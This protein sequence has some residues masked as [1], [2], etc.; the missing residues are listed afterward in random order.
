MDEQP[1]PFLSLG[2]LAMSLL[3]PCRLVLGWGWGWQ[4]SEPV[5]AT[6]WSRRIVDT[7]PAGPAS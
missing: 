7:S 4:A 3:P 6:A 5:G 2:V 1:P